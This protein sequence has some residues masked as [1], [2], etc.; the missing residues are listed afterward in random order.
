MTIHILGCGHRRF[1]VTPP[2]Q[3]GRHAGVNA[4]R[5]HDDRAAVVRTYIHLEID[6]TALLRMQ[7]ALRDDATTHPDLYS[8]LMRLGLYENHGELTAVTSFR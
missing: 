5:A 7:I 6:I 2:E 3:G 1:S 8:S 4:R